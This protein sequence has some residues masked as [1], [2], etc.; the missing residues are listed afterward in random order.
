M[1]CAS[2]EMATC[3]LRGN[4]VGMSNF[5][6]LT[7]VSCAVSSPNARSRVGI[8]ALNVQR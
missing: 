8:T 7:P 4:Y 2:L 6:Q 5:G 3:H 1:V